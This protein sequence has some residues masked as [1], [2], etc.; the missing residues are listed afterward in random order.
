MTCSSGASDDPTCGVTAYPEPEFITDEFD[1][2]PYIGQDFLIRWAY[3]TDPGLAFRG[4]VI[5]DIELLKNGTTRI[6]FDDAEDPIVS[7]DDTHAYNGWL[8]SNGTATQEHAYWI[9]VRDKTGFDADCA[10]A[11]G[12]T[13]EYANEAHGYGNAGVDD[14][15]AYTVLR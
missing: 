3:S 9:G 1:L 6:F 11:P 7:N 12:V 14:P 15:P 4:W 5:D 10:W 8:R 2:T 13:L